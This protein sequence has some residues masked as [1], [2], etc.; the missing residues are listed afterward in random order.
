MQKLLN[1]TDMWFRLSKSGHAHVVD[2][3]GFEIVSGKY[4][5]GSIMP[6]DAKLIERFRVS[7]T[8]LRETMK[9]LAAK[10]L[11]VARARIGTRVNEPVLW[12]MFD[13]DVLR[14]HIIGAS[15]P[16]FFVQLYQTRIAFQ[17]HA[18]EQAAIHGRSPEIDRLV[19]LAESMG[20]RDITMDAFLRTKLEF[21]QGLLIAGQNPF[22]CSF[23]NL[24]E[25]SIVGLLRSDA[26]WQ[27]GTRRQS[28]AMSCTNIASAI[29]KRA[30]KDAHLAM[31]NHLEF[32]RD[33]LEGT[34]IIG[35]TRAYTDR[36]A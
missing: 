14:W 30:E 1:G 10:G 13:R 17:P 2:S 27:D 8:V 23:G 21:H 22:M 35:Q 11:I 29:R 15:S 6:G 32:C 24:V 28:L 31:K 3:L 26:Q 12:N 18:A 16:A 36:T 34:S 19:H 33:S 25:A 20:R 5:V 9:T 7:R 4:P